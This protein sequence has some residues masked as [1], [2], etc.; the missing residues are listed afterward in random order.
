MNLIGKR[1]LF[2]FLSIAGLN[3]KFFRYALWLVNNILLLEQ[4]CVPN[5]VSE[6][7]LKEIY[8]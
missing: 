3:D 7:L 6:L 4:A 5:E 1:N 8:V 2:K